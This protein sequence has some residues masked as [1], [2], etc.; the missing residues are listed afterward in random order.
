MSDLSAL[1][2]E[3]TAYHAH[4]HSHTHTHTH[5]HTQT[6]TH[7][8]T[9]THTHTLGRNLTITINSEIPEIPRNIKKSL[10]IEKIAALCDKQESNWLENKLFV[11]QKMRQL[12]EMKFIERKELTAVTGL[13]PGG[14]KGT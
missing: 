1:H 3:P 9:H 6:H 5:R 14:L 2:T 13:L 12:I 4:T 10:E 8:L 7:R 11:E